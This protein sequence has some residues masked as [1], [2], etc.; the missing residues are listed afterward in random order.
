M[1][2]WRTSTQGQERRQSK[3]LR[4]CEINPGAPDR[5]R[6]PRHREWTVHPGRP[7]ARK[8][9]NEQRMCQGHYEFL[10]RKFSAQC[11]FIKL[12]FL[13]FPL[14]LCVEYLKG[15]ETCKI[16]SLQILHFHLAVS[17][18]KLS[19]LHRMCGLCC[20]SHQPL[21]FSSWKCR[22]P[23]S[24]LG[25]IQGIPSGW[26]ASARERR[27]VRPALI[28]PSLKGGSAGREREREK[29]GCL[30]GLAECGNALLFTVAFIP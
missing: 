23:G 6:E 29:R 4:L 26:T 18:D 14:Y 30:Q 8:D 17:S 2:A 9:R 13:C 21:L 15:Q 1:G 25:R 28:G 12:L 11:C 7:V 16:M 3:D 27:H 5:P 10:R 19:Q 24:S 22:L 20:L